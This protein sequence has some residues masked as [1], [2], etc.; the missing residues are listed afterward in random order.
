MKNSWVKV[1]AFNEEKKGGGED[2][3]VGG[4]QGCTKQSK[5]KEN[6]FSASH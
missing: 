2:G 5:R 3:G 4:G 1:K 6:L